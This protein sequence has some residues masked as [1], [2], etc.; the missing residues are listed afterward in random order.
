MTVSTGL[1]IYKLDL[2]GMQEVRWED[3]GTEPAGEYMIFYKKGNKIHELRT[4]FL[5]VH[6]QKQTN[7][8]ALSPKANY[9]D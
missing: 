1:S 6:K 9:T 5:S 8:V 2:V 7:S 4:G 3:T